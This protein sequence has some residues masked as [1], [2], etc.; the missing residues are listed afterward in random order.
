MRDN[1]TTWKTDVFDDIPSA[2]TH[3]TGDALSCMSLA[4]KVSLVLSA[5]VKW[6]SENGGGGGLAFL[7][8]V[9]VC[10]FCVRVR[11]CVHAY[12]FMR[13]CVCVLHS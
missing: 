6:F 1:V 11:E 4:A 7:L 5:F 2:A 9:Y 12:I 3:Q 8:R 13:L 10:V